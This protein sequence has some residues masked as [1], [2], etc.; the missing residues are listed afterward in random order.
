VVFS[1]IL[2]SFNAL[3]SFRCALSWEP[4][5]RAVSSSE[6]KNNAT[7]ALRDGESDTQDDLRKL[8]SR[9]DELTSEQ[10]NWQG[11]QREYEEKNSKEYQRIP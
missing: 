2:R 10:S 3:C 8:R 7:Q 9:V 5:S 1:K 11:K 6:R 4:F